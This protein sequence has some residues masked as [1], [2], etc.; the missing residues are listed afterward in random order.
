MLPSPPTNGLPIGSAASYEQS[1]ASA[2]TVSI[3]VP[4][5]AKVL[6]SSLRLSELRAT[7]VNSVAPLGESASQRHSKAR[8]GADQQQVTVVDR[9]GAC[10]LPIAGG[11]P[12]R[13]ARV[14][15]SVVG[16]ELPSFPV[17]HQIRFCPVPL[18]PA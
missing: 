15:H 10:S 3:W 16:H 18:S 9:F 1:L 2:E 11:T 12:T 7:R 4:V 17:S 8:P 6:A 14:A 5:S 13:G